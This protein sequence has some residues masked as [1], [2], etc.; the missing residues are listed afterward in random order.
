MMIPRPV[1][2]CRPVYT[3]PRPD[4]LTHKQSPAVAHAPTTPATTT[5]KEEKK[6]KEKKNGQHPTAH[7]A[8]SMFRK[9]LMP[10]RDIEARQHD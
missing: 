6:K 2:G 8:P 3:P 9:I 10:E 1:I 4:L 5:P 7:I